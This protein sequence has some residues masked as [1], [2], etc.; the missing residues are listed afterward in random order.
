MLLL[1]RHKSNPMTDLIHVNDVV[2]LEM[3]QREARRLGLDLATIKCISEITGQM[4]ITSSS[5]AAATAASAD[6]Y[7]E[8][9]YLFQPDDPDL[10]SKGRIDKKDD[11]VDDNDKVVVAAAVV[12]AAAKDAQQEEEYS[13]PTDPLTEAID[14]S[15]RETRSEAIRKI[16]SSAATTMVTNRGD[17]GSSTSTRA[18]SQP[19][20][21]SSETWGESAEVAAAAL[22]TATENAT[23]TEEGGGGSSMSSSTTRKQQPPPLRQP[24]VGSSMADPM[25]DWVSDRRTDNDWWKTTGF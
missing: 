13:S 17:A 14:E 10:I 2:S 21:L 18:S 4:R 8:E 20:P 7:G 3:L 23:E 25:D 22:N 6:D 12:A 5:S 15:F 24:M 16:H 11:D 19:S 1:N 9:P